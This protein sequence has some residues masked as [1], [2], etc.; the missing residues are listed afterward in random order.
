MEKSKTLKH[1]LMASTFKPN[2]LLLCTSHEY[3][4]CNKLSSKFEKLLAQIESSF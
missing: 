2:Q 3:L 1:E 4:L